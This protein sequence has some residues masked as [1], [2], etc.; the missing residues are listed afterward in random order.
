MQTVLFPTQSGRSIRYLKFQQEELGQF[1]SSLPIKQLASLLPIPAS[2]A[3]SKSWFD[4]EGK[5]ALQ[6]LKIFEDCSDTKLLARLNRDW[7]LQVFCGIQLQ[8][9]E[10]IKDPNLIWQ[11]RKFVARHL[12][13]EQF[14]KI[15]I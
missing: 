3:G 9:E 8:E 7:G 15:L 1:R 13:I 14:Q 5:I 2:N 11:I 4:N 10:S 6:F 12:S